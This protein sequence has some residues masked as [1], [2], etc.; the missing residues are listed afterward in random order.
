MA[1]AYDGIVAAAKL[2]ALRTKHQAGFSFDTPEALLLA[3]EE[4]LFVFDQLYRH[5][6]VKSNAAKGQGWDLLKTLA[7]EV[8]RVYDQ[9]FLQ[10]LGLEWGRL[11]DDN[12]FLST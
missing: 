12:E 8:E 7:E 6:C 2:F 3:Y 5:F 9:S 1:D 4:E 11:I 10:P